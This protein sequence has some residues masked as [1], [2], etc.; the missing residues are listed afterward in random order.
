MSG[1]PSFAQELASFFKGRP[2]GAKKELAQQVGVEPERVSAWLRGVR[3]DA[4]SVAGDG[5]D[6]TG[7]I[8]VLSRYTEFAHLAGMSADQFY[9]SYQFTGESGEQR[10]RGP[11]SSP[12]TQPSV[13]E[14]K[15]TPDDFRRLAVGLL[16]GQATR[17]QSNPTTN[18]P[19]DLQ[20]LLGQIARVLPPDEE[21]GRLL[22]LKPEQLAAQGFEEHGDPDD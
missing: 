8:V 10:R 3:P 16:L 14:T 1:V 12:A 5:E 22:P 17:E 18:P 11:R 19:P 20:D 7:I 15:F 6:V 21:G 4:K 9:A 2:R 13:K